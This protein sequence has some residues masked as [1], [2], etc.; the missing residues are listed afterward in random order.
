MFRNPHSV[1]GLVLPEERTT[2]LGCTP[3][4]RTVSYQC[5]VT[6][7]TNPPIGSTIWRGSAFSSCLESSLQ[8]ALVHSLYEIGALVVI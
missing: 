6:D 2:G 8:I 3:E 1:H 7:P 5:T 4:G